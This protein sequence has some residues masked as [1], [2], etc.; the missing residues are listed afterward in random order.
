MIPYNSRC[1]SVRSRSASKIAVLQPIVSAIWSIRLRRT[2]FPTPRRPSIMRLLAAL[3]LFV[4]SI[5]F[6]ACLRMMSRPAS[7]R[8]GM[9]TV[10]VWSQQPNFT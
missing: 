6:S 4:R 2:V 9:V 7:H 3:P 8:K 5:A 10:K 1:D